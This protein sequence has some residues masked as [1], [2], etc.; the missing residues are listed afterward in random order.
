MQEVADT[1]TVR[2]VQHPNGEFWF[3]GE[4]RFTIPPHWKIIGEMEISV[5]MMVDPGK[6]D[7]RSHPNG[8]FRK[9]PK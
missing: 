9:C 2:C 4:P 1:I 6:S 5:S 8:K 7:D 3:T